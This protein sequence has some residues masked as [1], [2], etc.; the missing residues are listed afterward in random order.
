MN[1][2]LA[3]KD[4]KR[5]YDERKYEKTP[6]TEDV[7]QLKDELKREKALHEQTKKELQKVQTKIVGAMSALLADDEPSGGGAEG[8]SGNETV[9]G[10]K[11][12]HRPGQ[13]QGDADQANETGTPAAGAA[14]AVGK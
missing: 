3:E 2:M 10:A 12:K 13:S 8:A 6:S 5:E 11:G 7:E 14:S 1:S 4:G 9:G